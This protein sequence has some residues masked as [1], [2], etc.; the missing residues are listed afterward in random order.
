MTSSVPTV[1]PPRATLPRGAGASLV[2]ALLAS[3]ASVGTSNEPCPIP[4]GEP[5]D[6]LIEPGETHFARLWKLTAGGENAEA[7]WSF[8]GTRLVLQRTDPEAGLDC[9]HMFVTDPETGELVEVST[10][11]GVTTCGYFLPG[12]RRVVF[13]S[14]HADMPGSPPPADWS[15]GY[16]WRVFPEYDLY[17]RDLDTGGLERLTNLWGYDAEATISP[18]GDRMVFTS[19]RSGD[20]E[21]WTADLDGSNLHQVT[22]R[23]G[24][25][26]GAFFSHDGETLVFRATQ[27]DESN[28]ET[29][30]ATY[31]ELLLDWKVRPHS[32]ELYLVDADGSNRRQLTDLG[33]ASFAPFFYPDDSRVV[34]SSNH[35]DPVPD[36]GLN[37]DLFSISVEGK[38]LERI[39]TYEGF[40]SFPMFSYDGRYFVFASN[41][42]GSRPGETN[43]FVAAW[44]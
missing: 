5:A 9:D 3:C 22:D 2:L 19:T 32:M 16:T 15:E 43:V 39:T 6:H 37:F 23:P 21:L 4:G 44:K 12:D 42:G 40:D 14:T 25:D 26:G 36:D 13:A 41:R 7:Y 27:F 29:S 10:G 24:Y 28:E 11:G 30:V 38:D 31:R 20:L 17:V 33:N 8:D 18:R 35:H 1:S 34:F